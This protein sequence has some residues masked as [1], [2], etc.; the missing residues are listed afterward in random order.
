ML[1]AVNR[2]ELTRV[3]QE[4]L[5]GVHDAGTDREA[6]ARCARDALR[7]LHDELRRTALGV[8]RKQGR[9]CDRAGVQPEDV[10]Q[11][12]MRRWLENPPG[13]A[14]AINPVATVCAWARTVAV[15]FLLDAS[16]RRTREPPV[17]SESIEVPDTAI[18]PDERLGTDRRMASVEEAAAGLKKYKHLHEVYVALRKDWD[19]PAPELARHVGLIGD[20]ATPDEERRAVVLAWQLR[21]RMTKRLAQLIKESPRSEEVP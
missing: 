6:A 5:R 20:G 13:Q 15:R 7:V 12:V 1:D 14:D 11:H 10:V 8:A 19:L 3:S 18:A 2:D 16:A 4:L 17:E 21:N 9:L